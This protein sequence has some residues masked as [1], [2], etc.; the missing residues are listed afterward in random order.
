[1]LSEKQFYDIIKLTPL[2][3]IDLLT[4]YKKKILLG[5]RLNQPAKGYYFIPG[6]IIFKGKTLEKACYRIF[7]RYIY[8]YYYFFYIIFF[9]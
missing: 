6:G 5:R 4:S 3:A 7:Y 1:M 8:Y 9:H 2:I